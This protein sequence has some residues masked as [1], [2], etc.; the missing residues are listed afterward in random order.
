[1][2]KK[3]TDSI[4]RIHERYQAPKNGAITSKEFV[5]TTSKK[6]RLRTEAFSNSTPDR[7][8]V[9]RGGV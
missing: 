3:K 6:G 4:M 7:I 5:K 8:H 2:L 9:E 1:L